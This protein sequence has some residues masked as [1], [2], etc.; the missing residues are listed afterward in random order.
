MIFVSIFV[1]KPFTITNLEP[2]T[3]YQLLLQCVAP[4]INDDNYEEHPI[5]ITQ[6]RTVS[7]KTGTLPGPPTDVSVVTSTENS[8]KLAWETPI[9][10]G[11]PVAAI[12]L[13]VRR[14]DPDCTDEG[15]SFQV[16]AE[17][18]VFSFD[19]L[20][21]K[22]EYNFVLRAL[23]E[24]DLVEVHGK[25]SSSAVCL[26]AW[27]NG[28]EA[29]ENLHVQ[30]RSPTSIA[31]SWQHALA[32]GMSSIQGYVVHYVQTRQLRKRSR[33]LVGQVR[34]LGDK[35]TV[36]SENRHAEVQGL[37]PGTVYKIMLETV[38]GFGDYSYDED[39]E[40]DGSE[41]NSATSSVLSERMPEIQRLYLSQ[42]LLVCTTAPLEP[43]VLIVS[44]FTSTQ[45]HLSW[46]KPLLM[47]PGKVVE[48]IRYVR[49]LTA[50]G[51]AQSLESLTAEWEVVGSVPRTGPILRVLK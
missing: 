8:I 50:A 29:A 34:D 43:P 18:C 11:I 28:I 26:S 17:T 27:T 16:S 2:E 35:L 12:H 20:A 10:R 30:S 21:P 33:G 6:S 42:P 51:L 9:E 5:N 15:R 19:F 36:G 1:E 23:T 24:D 14:K 40:S 32:Y 22:T 44:G 38:V 49:V 4:H 46:N 7:F 47:I 41:V 3:E 13:S 31:I 25:D 48:V 45:I 37:E 39:F